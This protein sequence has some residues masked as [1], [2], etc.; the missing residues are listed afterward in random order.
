MKNIFCL[1]V[2]MSL[3]VV[4]ERRKRTYMKCFLQQLPYDIALQELFDTGRNS[5]NIN[6]AHV[7]DVQFFAWF[8]HL[9]VRRNAVLNSLKYEN[10]MF[11]KFDNLLNLSLKALFC[12][13][14]CVVYVNKTLYSIVT[15]QN[16]KYKGRY[17]NHRL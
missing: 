13:K 17:S 16:T 4:K 1:L 2:G 9:I 6:Y 5:G 14:Y 11:L 7:S 15:Y 12:I 3:V 10:V 8:K